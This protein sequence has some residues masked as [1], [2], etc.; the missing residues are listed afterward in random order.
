MIY[1]KR[2]AQPPTLLLRI[3]STAGAGVLLGAAACSSDGNTQFAGSVTMPQDAQADVQT[4]GGGIT[5]LTVSPDSGSAPEAA[6]DVGAEP[7]G[8]DA[9]TAPCHPCGV[10]AIPQDAGPETSLVGVVVM[11]IS[12]F[13]DDSGVHGVVVNPNA[14]L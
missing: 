7:P 10:V 8:D 9:G 1:R 11:G 4:V 3:V 12:P 13:P 2:P 5:G 14:D 6:P